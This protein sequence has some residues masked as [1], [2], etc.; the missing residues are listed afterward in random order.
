MLKSDLVWW[1][2]EGR[3]A[4]GSPLGHPIRL[5]VTMDASLTGWGEHMSGALAQGTWSVQESRLHI[6]V[7][8]LRVIR[9]TLQHFCRDLQGSHVLIRTNNVMAKAFINRQG[10]TR[11]RT[12]SWEAALLFDWVE[13]NLHSILA[14]HLAGLDNVQ[15]DWLSRCRLR[16]TEWA[17]GFCNRWLGAKQVPC[18]A[19]PLVWLRFW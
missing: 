8:E 6:N 13:V 10:G 2:Q 18:L 14:E 1:L 15:A 5:A 19:H 12:L 4:R 16:K 3:L 9:L 11:S 17:G 7:L